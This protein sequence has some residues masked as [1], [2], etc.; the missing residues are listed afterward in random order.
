MPR[1]VW[2]LVIGMAIN[3]T[4]SSFLWPLNTIYMN[5]ELGKSLTVAGIV[6]MLNS[7]ATVIGNLFGGTIFDKIGGYR[8]ILLGASISMLALIGLNIWNTFIP[9]T[10]FL[11]LCGFGGGIIF[12]AMYALAG[13]VWPEGGRKT[14]NAIYIAQNVGVA[15]GAAL[16]GI[17]AN[18]SFQLA[19]FGN[20]VLL[21][22]FF[23]IALFGYK[24]L[25]AKVVKNKKQ[26]SIEIDKKDYAPMIS[27]LTVCVAFLLCWVGY[28]QW[29][30]TIATYTQQ[31]NIS[32]EQYSLLWT[33]NGALIVLGQPFLAPIVKRIKSLKTQ[34]VVG[35]IIFMISY[36]VTSVA[37]QFTMFV[38]GM[39]ILTL[40]EM[41][42]WP[43]IP[44]IAA[45][46]APT[47]REGFYQGVVNS[48]GTVGKMIGPILGGFLVDHYGM[49]T[50]F[51]IMPLLLII[52][53][54]TTL[55]YDKPLKGKIKEAA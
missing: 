14:F 2:L 37:E 45:Q 33:I 32:L 46:L 41:F 36:V 6:L 9:Y 1:A 26:E 18:I 24:N 31:I 48:T 8:S 13:T 19:F 7:I 35:L 27:L 10:I 21:T 52:G 40:G 50:M 28:V 34:I 17:I 25:N 51:L 29:Q 23:F 22:V 43:V 38:A 44:T 12:P 15:L 47:G 39:V 3:V 54:A 53:I 20:L 4:G 16:A 11:S 49:G 30:T 5:G 42:V 55:V